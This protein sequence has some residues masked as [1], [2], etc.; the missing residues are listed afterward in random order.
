MTEAVQESV[1]QF[2][3]CWSYQVAAVLL[4]RVLP[5]AVVSAKT[6]ERVTKR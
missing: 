3:L 2:G 5:G 4:A 1:S 6:V